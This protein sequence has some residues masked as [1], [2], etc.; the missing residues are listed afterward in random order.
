MKYLCLT[1]GFVFF[2]CI[3]LSFAFQ[4]RDNTIDEFFSNI[5]L[6]ISQGDIQAYLSFYAEHLREREHNSILT[7]FDTFEV[8]TVFF[9][10]AHSQKTGA[11]TFRIHVQVLFQNSY[12][13]KIETWRADLIRVR[14]QWL[15]Q[16]KT[17][18]GE[19]KNLYKVNIP[20]ERVERADQVEIDHVDINMQFR[21]ALLFYDNIPLTETALLVI[22]KG[23]VKFSP[24]SPREKHQLELIFK[25]DTLQDHLEYV[26]VRCSNEFFKRNIKIVKEKAQN[27][28]VSTKD[29][30]KARSLFRR[31]QPRSFTIENSLTGGLLS[32]LPKG[33]E[34]VF[35]FKAE[36]RGSFTY[37]YSP[38]A[39][40][41]VNL[42]QWEKNRIINL[43]S[44]I[45]DEEKKRLFIS[46]SRLFEVNDY[47]IDIY[48]NPK[49]SYIS[50]KAR[51]TVE[52]KVE[53]LDG[54]KLKLH[55]NL[56]VLRINDGKKH[57]LFYTR[58]KLRK[59]LY[60][61]FY[62]MP[63]DEK[64]QTI[65]VFYRGKLVPE[66]QSEDV[67]SSY[68]YQDTILLNQP[69]FQTHLYTR[70]AYWYPAPSDEEYFTARLKII[71]PPGFTCVSNGKLVE[72]S[73]LESL[74][75]VED[76]EKIGSSVFIF[77]NKNPLKY[78]SFIVGKF[79]TM[80]EVSS[81]LPFQYFRGTEIHGFRW[82]LFGESMKIFNFY[83][84]MFGVYPFEKFSIVHR[85]WPQGGGHSP[86]SFIILNERPRV[87]GQR[88]FQ[89]NGSP[90]NL[91]RWKEYFIAH[92]IAHQWWGQG[93]SWGSYHDQWLSEGL[94]QFAS[95]TYLRE[96]YGD[97]AYSQIMKKFSS[98]T[99]KKSEW[100]AILMGSRISYGDFEA[101]QAI[102]YNKA[103]LVLN[104]L[105]DLVGEDVFF[106]AL[107]E[108]FE[109]YKYSAPRS[110]EFF[111][112]FE[113][114]SGADLDVFFKGWFESYR[115]PDVKVTHLVKKADLG[116]LLKLNVVQLK[117]T[118]DFP[119]WI[120]WKE[121]GDRVRKNVRISS[122]VSEFVFERE[123]KP[124]NIKI[125]PD[126]WV[127]GKFH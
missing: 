12:A 98:W 107:R 33:E 109:R 14:G 3:S 88:R 69:K 120:E 26:Y 13:V 22:G 85:F 1:L 11:E 72:R 42:Y 35:E 41:E 55:P 18:L 65:E 15:I 102:I 93:L 53:S 52:S 50:G 106:Q 74:E 92:E 49:N 113:E 29:L 6:S 16:E 28:E 116:Y 60:V 96:K 123:R 46:F 117:G 63:R 45:L 40:E 24:S 91:S 86:A 71:V 105:K 2:L 34:V 67:I 112:T 77:E 44:P 108:F 70:S 97:G 56:E 89:P 76:L 32:F 38:F 30:N 57:E 79:I 126:D 84:K 90:V 23:Q 101:Y 47:E 100:G 51:L 19:V 31:F 114:I 37:I 103:A 104:M 43:Y 78:L 80:D 94:A 39:K 75:E 73:T 99:R 27:S 82:D 119:L 110:K 95:V 87:V 111:D 59:F 68:Q 118:F 54:I 20:S 66:K 58:D 64:T 10:I 81:P 5:Q 121:N 4:E 61:Y 115:L 127:P 48:F 62:N 21:D 9:R 122:A 25:K 17:L 7:L 125:N 8:E 36:D 83:Q 124:E